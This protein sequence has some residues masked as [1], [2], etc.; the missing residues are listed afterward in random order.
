MSGV[1]DNRRTLSRRHIASRIA[2]ISRTDPDDPRLPA[3]RERADV[4]HV[5]EIAEWARRAAA[6]LPPLTH[7]EIL[8]VERE[9]AALDA[10]LT[11]RRAS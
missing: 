5:A 11:R 7:E 6:A 9:V 1:A 10:R 2:V 8:A 3:L 4:L